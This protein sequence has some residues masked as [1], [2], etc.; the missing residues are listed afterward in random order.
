MS[1]DVV[2]M[3]IEYEAVR[4]PLTLCQPTAA[5]MR[6]Y[7]ITLTWAIFNQPFFAHLLMAELPTYWTK[8]VPI[9]ATDGF[10]LFLNPDGFFRYSLQERAFILFHE[11]M[12]CVFGDCILNQAWMQSGQLVV[13]TE[14]LPYGPEL[15]NV[16]SD[17][18]INAILIEGKAG[19]Y[20]PEWLYDRAIT[21]DGNR[22]AVEIYAE[23]YHAAVK[24][25]SGAKG[26]AGKGNA[27][28]GGIPIPMP[29]TGNQKRFD[30]HLAPGAK[31]A[32]DPAEVIKGRSDAKFKA[33]IQSAATVA[34]QQGKLPSSL[35]RLIGAILNPKVSWQEHLRAAMNRA[36]GAEG[37]DWR[38]ADKRMIARDYVG[39]RPVYF[40]RASGHSAGTIVIGVDTSG[41]IGP[42]QLDAFFGEMTGILND[43]SPERVVIIQC[44]AEVGQV[45]EITDL[46]E[47]DE[48]RVR[49]LTGGGGTDFRPVFKEVSDM[50]LQPD[51]VVYLTDLYGT[52]PKREPGYPV[53]WGVI[54]TCDKAP[55]GEIVPIN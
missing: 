29:N 9:A 12:H 55:F 1:T 36:N 51:A 17:Y 11:V 52:F 20:N 53:V 32:Q 41:S 50:G 10:G 18:V 46:A 19:Q 25:L 40:A 43:L 21:P 2:K 4:G 23:L 42:E 27:G 54:G 35:K 6:D 13:G 30:K 15:M 49:G 16:S 22:A 28:K 7:D 45:D 33:A 44:D 47:L 37:L 26:G 5:Q 34:E 8:D 38:Y 48:W 39:H 24:Q 14:V 3:D 31:D